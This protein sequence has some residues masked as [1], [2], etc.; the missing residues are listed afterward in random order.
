[1][2]TQNTT[3]LKLIR[4]AF[5]SEH[6]P[7]LFDG[8]K[9]DDP[10]FR[11]IGQLSRCTAD[12]DLIK[13]AVKT[14]FPSDYEEGDGDTFE[15]LDNKIER[16]LNQQN[17]NDL[18]IVE[19]E[20]QAKALISLAK[21]SGA[22]FFHDEHQRAYVELPVKGKKLVCQVKSSHMRRWLHLK[23][24]ET[25]KGTA[26]P[27]A[28]AQ[29]IDLL[30]AEAIHNEGQMQT[31]T[32]HAPFGNA[33]IYN[34]ANS[35]S[36]VAIINADG[37]K[38]S[39]DS[40]V[41]FLNSPTLKSL[42]TP[43]PSSEDILEQFRKI[44]GLSHYHF[45]C[46][47]AFIINAMRPKGPYI[48]LLVQGEQ[49]SG[50]SFLCSVIKDILDPSSAPK[51]SMPKSERDLMIVAQDN[52]L[53]LFDNMSGL[54]NEMSDAL[55]RL[56][57]GTGYA[58]RKI[59]SD[60]DLQVFSECCP[61]ICNGISGISERPD[62]IDRSLA[63]VLPSMEENSRRLERYILADIEAINPQLL[64]KLFNIASYA[65]KN[66]D[67][68]EPPT[69]FRMADAAQWL[70]AAEPATGLPE[71]SLLDAMRQS[72]NDIVMA[73]L[74]HQTIPLALRE[75]V[76]KKPFKGYFG[77][78]TLAL[79]ATAYRDDNKLPKNPSH[80]S[81]QLKRL[82]PALKRVGFEISF[83]DKD[84]GGRGISIALKTDAQFREI[85]V[86]QNQTERTDRGIDV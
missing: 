23:F 47:L 55:C 8:K 46:V 24:Y 38:I 61:F 26:Q 18:N 39:K 7:C 43:D 53:L 76:D 21:N 51:L 44:L 25:M 73:S 77:E 5:S 83:I 29:A 36:E 19:G 16:I 4:V 12:A 56:S 17:N 74:E 78:L 2:Q 57:T 62:L 50:K 30:E 9:T 35:A 11:F 42:P 13:R 15:T 68:V 3:S 64:D 79:K 49:G 20:S 28:I 67:H 31:Y 32:R 63:L 14:G 6:Y 71:G 10:T 40:P 37:Y 22:V 81:H 86:A 85:A 75:L 48:C 72:Q 60:N 66:L 59:Y 70:L 52:A 45:H 84:R 33:A 34:L 65:I 54:S 80:L 41:K 69:E 1:M 27:T 82:A 58:T